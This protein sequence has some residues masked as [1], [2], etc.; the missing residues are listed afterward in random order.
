MSFFYEDFI[1][2]IHDARSEQEQDSGHSRGGDSKVTKIHGTRYLNARLSAL[3][4]LFPFFLCMF[5][6]IL[7]VAG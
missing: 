2:I 4:I 3:L 6:P 7:V 1:P 5:W